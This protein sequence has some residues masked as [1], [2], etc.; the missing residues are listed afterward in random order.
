VRIEAGN[1]E[2]WIE[3]H[4]I[5]PLSEEVAHLPVLNDRTPADDGRS[6][7]EAAR[8]R[9]QPGYRRI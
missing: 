4:Q 1:L 8:V 6:E 3:A 7:R 5:T 2:A 9:Q